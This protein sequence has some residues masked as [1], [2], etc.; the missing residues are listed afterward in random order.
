MPVVIHGGGTIEGI[1]VGGLPDGTVD[2]DMLAS[3]AVTSAKIVGSAVTSGS[4]ASS[5][6]L[7]KILQV[8]NVSSAIA[9]AAYTTNTWVEKSSQS[10]TPVG[11]GS[12]FAFLLP[13]SSN[14]YHDSASANV[15]ASV[16]LTRNVN[17]EGEA[18]VFSESVA[19]KV[20]FPLSSLYV[21]D[22]PLSPSSVIDTPTYTAGE[23]IVYKIYFSNSNG[24]GTAAIK[25]SRGWS[26]WE[27]GA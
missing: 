27:I 6:A 17:S 20:Y 22:T 15:Y 24:T 2:A 13:F 1:A 8:V 26:M 25:G 14:T 12:K 9:S 4:L 3:N 23:S 21:I 5:V 11:L 16:K 10:I 18:T 7:G 19:N